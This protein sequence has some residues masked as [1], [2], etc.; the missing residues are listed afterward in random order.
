MDQVQ[1][2]TLR[3][4]DLLNLGRNVFE[5]IKLLRLLRFVSS[6]P[7]LGIFLRALFLLMP[8]LRAKRD[9]NLKFV[10]DKTEARFA[11][12]TDRKDFMSYV[13]P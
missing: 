10:Q 8:S 4:N 13:R 1:Y 2:F 9:A 12:E 3:S 6:N 5:S 11:Q 7:V